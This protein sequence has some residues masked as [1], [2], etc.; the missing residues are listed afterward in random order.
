M[1]NISLVNKVQDLHQKWNRHRDIKKLADLIANGGREIEPNWKH[2]RRSLP[3][4]LGMGAFSVPLF[5]QSLE[6]PQAQETAIIYETELAEELIRDYQV[7]LP[8]AHSDA[9]LEGTITRYI[10]NE[11][12]PF[13]V[14]YEVNFENYPDLDLKWGTGSQTLNGLNPEFYLLSNASTFDVSLVINDKQGNTYFWGDIDIDIPLH[15][16]L[17]IIL[18]ATRFVPVEQI[19]SVS[20]SAENGDPADEVTFPIANKN[21]PV[22]T[23]TSTW[24]NVL[25]IGCRIEK[26]DGTIVEEGIE[27]LI[28]FKNGTPFENRS[29]N[30]AAAR[31]IQVSE[32]EDSMDKEFPLLRSIGVNTITVQVIWY[33]GHPDDGGNWTIEPLWANGWP[34]DPRGDTIRMDVFRKYVERAKEEGFQVYVEMRAWPYQNDRDIEWDHTTF[35]PVSKISYSFRATEEWWIGKGEGLNNMFLFYLDDLITLG[36]DGVFLGAETGAL[37]QSG[38]IETQEFYNLIIDQ[39]RREG[40]NGVISYANSFFGAGEFVPSLLIPGASGI[41]YENMDAVSSTYYP[42]LANKLNASTLEM[43]ME[44]REDIKI[45]FKPRSEAYKLPTIIE[46]CWCPAYTTCAMNPVE[47]GNERNIED[48]RRYFNAILR[49]FSAENINSENPWISTMT[50]AEY[51]IMEDIYMKDFS[52]DGIVDSP[53]LN[54]SAG[55]TH[56]QYTIKVFFSDKPAPSFN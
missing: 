43:Q 42:T 39:Y 40:F 1:I 13:S 4:F 41:P 8:S 55:N 28:Y 16:E 15:N 5:G 30:T 12:I 52:Q 23:L 11:T 26:N 32:L 9:V 34:P 24:P 29:V 7:A 46:D 48:Q 18:D 19:K 33:F 36:V 20:W 49:E 38:G 21:S 10:A 51:K 56:L 27:A 37:E 45:F 3:F 25:D 53:W 44:V 50:M 54:K 31:F 47:I 2:I 14:R 35:D 17:P 22:T 6:T